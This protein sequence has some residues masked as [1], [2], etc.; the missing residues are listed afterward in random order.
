MHERRDALNVLHAILNVHL[1][2]K[3][4]FDIWHELS[5]LN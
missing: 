2:F 4:Y 3:Q 5:R 1:F